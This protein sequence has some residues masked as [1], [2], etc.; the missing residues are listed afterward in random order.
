MG[1]I[2]KAT[3]ISLGNENS[4]VL[5]AVR[6]GE[7]CIFISGNS[8]SDIDLLINIGVYRD[9]NM[10]EPAMS[11]LIQQQIGLNLTPDYSNFHKT[12]SFDMMNGACGFLNAC[13]LVHSLFLNNTINK[14]LIVSS[15]VHSSKE[16]SKD[17]PYTHLG[18]AA[19][20]EKDD[21]EQKGFQKFSFHT[22]K[23]NY[24]GMEGYINVTEHGEN[25]RDHLTIDIDHEFYDRLHVYTANM[26]IQF[27][28][29]ENLDIKKLKFI[30]SQ[31][32]QRFGR[33]VAKTIG[34][35][36]N[37]VLNIYDDFGDP[38]TSA[39]TT[40][41]HAAINKGL[42]HEND[43]VLFIGAGSGLSVALALYNV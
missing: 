42:L 9:N 2:I 5:Y 20:L 14:V 36:E 23:D 12:F 16:L 3:E 30:T 29:K 28:E 26:V 8:N 40:G 7:Q 11:T 13:Q 35:N 31:P 22:T 38:N 43:Q 4:S 37:Q 33:G 21:F 41:F 10:C 15:D 6:A 17:F 25:A 18:A 19:L 27:I 34:M 24:F 39:L 32:E 1:T